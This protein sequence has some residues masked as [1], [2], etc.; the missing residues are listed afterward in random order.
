MQKAAEDLKK[1]A[2][3]KAQEKE[4]FINERV[5]LLNADGL[6]EGNSGMACWLLCIDNLPLSFCHKPVEKGMYGTLCFSL[7]CS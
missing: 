2:L 6:G 3:A 7:F 4:K 1:E 5:G